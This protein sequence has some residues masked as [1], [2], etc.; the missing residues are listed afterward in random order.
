MKSS[1]RLSLLAAATF[2]ARS[3]HAAR[4]LDATVSAPP[5]LPGVGGAAALGHSARALP[6]CLPALPVG[7]DVCNLY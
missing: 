4:D 7:W 5:A 6:R 2:L 3:A 1:A